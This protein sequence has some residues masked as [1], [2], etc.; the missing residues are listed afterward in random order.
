MARV[1]ARYALALLHAAPL[2]SVVRAAIVRA[3]DATLRPLRRLAPTRRGRSRGEL[4]RIVDAL[5]R[6]PR[7][8]A[9]VPAAALAESYVREFPVE[10]AALLEEAERA[11]AGERVLFGRRLA[12]GEPLRLL[13][14]DPKA[15]W[16]EARA[17]DLLC[18]A[19]AARVEPMLRARARQHAAARVEKLLDEYA[20]G[21]PAHDGAPLEVAVRALHLLGTLELLDGPRAL[22][23]ALAARLAGALVDERAWLAASLEDGGACPANHLLGQ[24]VAIYVLDLALGDARAARRTGRA[25]VREALRQVLPD[26]A[27][28]EASSGYHRFA[29]ELILTAWRASRGAD[30]AVAATGDETAAALGPIV[31]RMAH[32]LAV[33]LLPDGTEPAFGDGDDARVLPL[34]T[35][36][37]RAHDDLVSSCAVLFDDPALRL[38]GATLPDEALWIAGPRALERWAA[39]APTPRPPVACLPDGGLA[40][41]RGERLYVA[42]RA[43]ST[44]QRGV[45]GHGHNDQLSLVV[46]AGRPIVRE[47]GTGSYT[48]DPLLRDRLRGTAAHA[49]LV[50]EGR[51]QNPIFDGRPFALPDRARGS[52]RGAIGRDGRARLAAG[53]QGYRALGVEHERVVEIDHARRLLFVEDRLH[54]HRRDGARAP[55]GVEAR[56]PVVDAPRPL[57]PALRARLMAAGVRADAPAI[58]LGEDVAVALVAATGAMRARVLSQPASA[59]YGAV[60]SAPVVSFSGRLRVPG[61]CLFVWALPASESESVT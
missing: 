59:V 4:A 13:G 54:D 56:F 30:D 36:P 21:S 34:H 35:R 49:T 23:P 18:V 28:F 51:E 10:H 2:S 32:A 55:V 27:H 52:L 17:A 43:G 29:L 58:A 6:A 14:D 42:L 39:L 22:P 5:A 37:L 48:G 38:P 57:T 60:A 41:A 45:G 61:F 12:P 40:I 1:D 44:G 53:H 3:R 25:V 24:R 46:W 26:G 11:L 9:R 16:E 8:F 47:A 15:A 50:I 20:V 7:L 33:W 19:A 31:H